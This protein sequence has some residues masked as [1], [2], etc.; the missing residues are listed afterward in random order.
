MIK[1]PHLNL[2]KKRLKEYNAALKVVAEKHGYATYRH[3]YARNGV[4]HVVVDSYILDTFGNRYMATHF[5][6]FCQSTAIKP[7]KDDVEESECR[8]ASETRRK[9]GEQSGL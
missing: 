7:F 1:Q 4:G 2:T 6:E 3:D 9:R 5:P 8:I